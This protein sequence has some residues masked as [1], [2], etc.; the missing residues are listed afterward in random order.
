MGLWSLGITKPAL[1]PEI[2]WIFID[3][4]TEDRFVE[5]RA[6]RGLGL[7]AKVAA[8]NWNT[9]WKDQIYHDIYGSAPTIKN[10]RR[11]G[12]V[13]Y[14][15]I[16]TEDKPL[17][18]EPEKSDSL[19]P[20]EPQLKTEESKIFYKAR[21]RSS[22]PFYFQVE[23]ILGKEL[24]RFFE[25]SFFE[26]LCKDDNER[27]QLILKILDRIHNRIKNFLIKHFDI[28]GNPRRYYISDRNRKRGSRKVR[29]KV[30]GNNTNENINYLRQNR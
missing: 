15:D 25:P 6:R 3:A 13:Q 1:S 23:E 16:A 28:V 20:Q 18:P 29:K 4:L 7:P 2:G 21:E 11:N 24:S 5:M 12:I 19:T 8:Y 26:V 14:Y 27:E 22:I 9:I 10:E 17:K 30:K